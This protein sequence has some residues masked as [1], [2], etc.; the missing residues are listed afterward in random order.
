[1]I[2]LLTYSVFEIINSYQE[3]S[4]KEIKYKN[5]GR[6]LGDIASIYANTNKADSTLN[7]KAK[8]DINRMI[9]DDWNYRKL[10]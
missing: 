6:R 2:I 5:A 9:E 4:K 3:I 8:H 1:M 7:W 10:N